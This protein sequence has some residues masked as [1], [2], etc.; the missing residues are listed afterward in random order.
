[1]NASTPITP[2][3]VA[4]A[5]DLRLGGCQFGAWPY[6]DRGPYGGCGCP[7]GHPGRGGPPAPGCWGQG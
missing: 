4:A 3:M 1:M 6:G 5:L 7:G 2:P